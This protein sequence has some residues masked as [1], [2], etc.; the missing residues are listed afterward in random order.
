MTDTAAEA[1]QYP[2]D[3]GHMVNKAAGGVAVKLNPPFRAESAEAL[4]LFTA[5]FDAYCQS[6]WVLACLSPAEVGLPVADA[7]WRR[8]QLQ[9]PALAR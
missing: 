1:P 9:G 8:G 4:R 6:A 3:V 2:F 7:V 5:D